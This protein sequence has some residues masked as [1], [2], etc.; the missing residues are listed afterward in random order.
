MEEF[1]KNNEQKKSEN[2]SIQNRDNIEGGK[3]SP[4]DN[5]EEQNSET[6]SGYTQNQQ[7]DQ[8][9]AGHYSYPTGQQYNSY[10]QNNGYYGSQTPNYQ[11]NGQYQ[12]YNPNAANGRIAYTPY[13]AAP[14]KTKTRKPM[15]RAA[16][17]IL[18][19]GVIILSGVCGFGGAYLANY[20]FDRTNESG[21]V[22]VESGNNAIVQNDREVVIYK[23]NDDEVSVDVGVGSAGDSNLSYS[24][25]A[26]IVKDSVVEITTEYNVQSSW[27]QY[28]TQ[29]AGSGVIIST[30]GYIITN[31]HVILNSDSSAVADSITVRL[32]DGTEY[33]ASVVSYDVDM[34][35]AILK[36]EAKDL[37]AAQCGDS[38]QLLVGEELVIVGNPLGELG[39]SVSNGIVSATEREI[40]VSGVTMSLIQTNAAV[41]PGNSG[42]G[43]FNMKGQLV[44]IVNAKSSGTGIEGLG[45]AIPINEVL[46]ITEQLLE[47]GYV[48]GRAMIGVK[49]YD[50]ENSS[51]MFYYNVK[52]GV[53]VSGLTEG[54]NDKALQVG[55]RVVAVNGNE[56][57]E[58]AD[59]KTIVSSSSIGDVLKF[60]IY[61]N[62]KLMEVNVTCYE[63]IPDGAG[64]EIK[65]SEDFESYP[66][67]PDGSRA[68][69]S[70]DFEAF[71]NK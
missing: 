7:N 13:N 43:M 61:R 71:Y 21:S 52:A 37:K 3:S 50:A 20:I 57:S 70:Y 33:A 67:T 36:I 5:R 4:Q 23:S 32:T 12:Y 66:V 53:Y 39:G 64:S 54:Y 56:I 38:D 11:N 19:C 59:I 14:K 28:V 45:F 2:D 69:T 44:G 63:K 18:C 24:E 65:F 31:T 58:S 17:A 1:E 16:I 27:F 15:S 55:D 47:Y 10:G 49:F 41:N 9:Y 60:Q 62:G 6:L 30:D 35:V 51:M 42:G 68:N 34:D 8:Q 22:G 26:A 40:Q 25:V 29:G 48:R 46:N